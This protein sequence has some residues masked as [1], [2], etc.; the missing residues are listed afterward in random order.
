MSAEVITLFSSKQIREP[1]SRMPD[2]KPPAEADWRSR[3]AVQKDIDAHEK[4]R[5]V[6]QQAVAWTV[7]AEAENLPQA[8]IEQ[9]LQDTAAFYAEMQQAA[10]HLVICMPTDPKA[11]VDLLMYLEKNF[12]ILPEE[13]RGQSLALYML[14]TVRLSLRG[15]AKYGKHP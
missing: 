2:E 3:E 7:A 8:Q 11:L 15:V 4:A 13:I 5:K 10:R 12:S 1:V 9:A 6:Y 14:R